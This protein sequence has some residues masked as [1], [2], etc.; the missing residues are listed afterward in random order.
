LK[1]KLNNPANIERR[2]GHSRVLGEAAFLT[3][4]AC[5]I[6]TADDKERPSVDAMASSSRI[7]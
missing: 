1:P 3:V 6:F 7:R 2:R 4:Y 5:T